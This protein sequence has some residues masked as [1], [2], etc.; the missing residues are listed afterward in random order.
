MAPLI[1]DPYAE[2]LVRAV[3]VDVFTRLANGELDPSDV[4]R[5]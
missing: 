3:G 5:R 4:R 2:P 1:S